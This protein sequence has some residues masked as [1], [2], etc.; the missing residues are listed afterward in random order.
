MTIRSGETFPVPDIT[1][2]NL[3]YVYK[4]SDSFY[5]MDMKSYETLS[6]DSKIIGTHKDCLIESLEVTAC[7][8]NEKVISIEWPKSIVLSVVKTE[9]GFK[10]NTV[11]NTTKPATMETGMI[12]QVPLHIQEGDKIK[13]N[14]KDKTYIEKSKSSAMK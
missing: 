4:D 11:S 13:I 2:K 3:S 14:T 12:I 5:F 6:I 9:P 1:Y 8:F 10:G 7:F